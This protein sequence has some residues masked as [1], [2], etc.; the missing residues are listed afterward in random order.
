MTAKALDRMFRCPTVIAS[1]PI[2]QKVPDH[3]GGHR[4]QRVAEA[5]VDD[6]VHEG[7]ADKRQVAGDVRV[8]LGGVHLVGFEHRHAGQAEIRGRG[9]RPGG[10][11]P[12]PAAP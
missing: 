9:I 8:A 3:E 4:Q 6:D 1:Q 10:R 2:A 12:V 11:R 5:A 7:D